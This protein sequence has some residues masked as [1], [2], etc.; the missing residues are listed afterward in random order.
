M[1]LCNKIQAVGAFRGEIKMFLYSLLLTWG[2][3]EN[4][5]LD[6]ESAGEAYSRL[7]Y[8]TGVLGKGV[9]L[10]QALTCFLSRPQPRG[11]VCMPNLKKRV[12]MLDPRALHITLEEC[13]SAARIA[14]ACL[15]LI[16]QTTHSPH[17]P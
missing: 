3:T 11:G 7:A 12:Q 5:L 9:Y 16:R 15:M 1:D 4:P 2:D 8:R 10:A 6:F 14:T 13:T 17:A